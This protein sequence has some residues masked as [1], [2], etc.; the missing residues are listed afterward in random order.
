MHTHD[1][2]FWGVIISFGGAA[3]VLVWL[4]FMLWRNMNDKSK[5]E[6]K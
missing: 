6:K 3:L 2:V 4:L 5:N 1:M